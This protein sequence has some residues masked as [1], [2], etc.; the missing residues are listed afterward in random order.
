MEVKIRNS[1]DLVGVTALA[2]DLWFD[3]DQTLSNYDG[4]SVSFRLM[5]SPASKT[6]ASGG[7]LLLEIRNVKELKVIDTEK[8][9]LYDFNEIRYNKS[10]QCI[11]VSTGIPIVIE[12]Y[13]T[14][15]DVTVLFPVISGAELRLYK[16]SP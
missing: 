12:I 10:T 7:D 3:I 16:N 2:H 14:C 5:K 4:K 1:K 11:Q 13:V 9:G 8:V 6:D 15:L